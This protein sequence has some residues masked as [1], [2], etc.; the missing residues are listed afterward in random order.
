MA[1]GMNDFLIKP[2]SPDELF[3]TLLRSLSRKD[4]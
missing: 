4:V 1:A 3:A 2:F